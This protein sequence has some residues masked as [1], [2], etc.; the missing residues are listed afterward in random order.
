MAMTVRPTPSSNGGDDAALA[1]SLRQ[2]H[3]RDHAN[4]CVCR[5]KMLARPHGEPPRADAARRRSRSLLVE[6]DLV[7]AYDVCCLEPRSR[8]AADDW[9]GVAE[10]IVVRRGV[11]VVRQ[12]S[13][14]VVAEPVAPV[15]LGV[16]E[17]QVS[18]PGSG[19]DDCTVLIAQPSLLLDAMGSAEGRA[20]TLRRND[21]L[22]IALARR[23]L[24]DSEDALEQQELS[25]QLL[26]AMGRAFMPVSRPRLG[27]LQL[28]RVEQVRA[29]LA[30]DPASRWDLSRVARAVQCSPFHLA[31][32]F[33]TAT[34]GTISDYLL[35]LRV[36]LALNRLAE[37]EHDLSA[38]ALD[39][40]FAHHSH[41]GACFKRTLG[42]TPSAARQMLSHG[43]VEQLRGLLASPGETARS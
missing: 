23:S 4:R 35:Q 14:E 34:G 29:L 18:H 39:L 6:S 10:V 1:G 5:A 16:G 9:T 17:Y 42:L 27:R 21:L 22:A 30:S 7:R 37:G 43:S 32:Q 19:G 13:G 24:S 2:S 15:V 8:S 26:A 33:R 36:G 12:R 38:L 31:R 41:F 28:A 40:G 20:G 3:H 25:L 11:F